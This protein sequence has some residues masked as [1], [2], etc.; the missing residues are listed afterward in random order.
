MKICKVL[1][2][3]LSCTIAVNTLLASGVSANAASSSAD[4]KLPGAS[5]TDISVARIWDGSS[6]TSWFTNDKDSYDIYTAEE[7]AGLNEL[8]DRGAHYDRFRGV[9]INLMNDIVL[10][11]TSSLSSWET[12]PPKNIWNPIGDMGAYLKDGYCPFAGT[13]N[14][15]GHTI[16]GLYSSE[17][18][19]FFLKGYYGYAGLFECTAGAIITDLKLKDSYIYSDTFSGGIAAYDQGSIYQRIEIENCK[20]ISPSTAGGIVGMP[21]KFMHGEFLSAMVY[22]TGL[23]V[24]GIG[25]N[26]LFFADTYLEELNKNPMENY[27]VFC[28]VKDCTINGGLN[29]GGI[30]ASSGLSAGFL[31]CFTENCRF[32]NN[33]GAIIS[34]MPAE[35]VFK[36]CYQYGSK[37]VN[38]E[39]VTFLDKGNYKTVKKSA[40][41]SSS[42][43]KVLGKQYITSK[44]GGSPVLKTILQA[45]ISIALTGKQAN[46]EWS[47]VKNAVKYRVYIKNAE[48]KYKAVATTKNTFVSIKNISKGK[49]YDILIRA[50]FKDGT[51]TT[52]D[53]G[54]FRLM[55]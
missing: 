16:S 53:C 13:F 1:S 34:G 20:I 41:S 33:P 46:M 38:G 17:S 19:Y 26:P 25:L 47:P 24:T 43:A 30:V 52:V 51:Y 23:A 31:G 50:Y 36:Q 8:C 37:T 21:H 39:K 11:D 6:D 5:K 42:F 12:A 15:N 7:L 10:N 49:S 14:G 29:S 9:T 27:F 45:P 28:K 18:E 3:I 2:A 48:G 55:A 22:I 44:D 40:L 35:V 54:K 4:K 32:G